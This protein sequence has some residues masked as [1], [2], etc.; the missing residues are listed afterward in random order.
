VVV[1]VGLTEEFF[2]HHGEDED[3]YSEHEAEVAER[4]HRPTDYTDQKVERR[5]RLGQLE[6]SQL[7]NINKTFSLI[8]YERRSINSKTN[9]VIHRQ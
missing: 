7:Q 4:A 5:P 8:D 3:D 9:I 6:H 2:A 1:D